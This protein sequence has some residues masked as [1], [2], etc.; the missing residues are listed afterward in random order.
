VRRMV[1]V[2]A[3]LVGTPGRRTIEHRP[4]RCGVLAGSAEML[5]SLVGVAAAGVMPTSPP[6][7]H[8][9][10]NYLASRKNQTT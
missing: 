4:S 3:P 2:P 8:M 5:A 10:C 1:T 9:L 6:A 7:R